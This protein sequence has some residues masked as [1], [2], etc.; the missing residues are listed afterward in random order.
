MNEEYEI[1]KIHMGGPL[2]ILR[3]KRMA[4]PQPIFKIRLK[5]PR[6]EK[7]GEMEEIIQEVSRPSEEMEEG[8]EIIQKPRAEIIFKDKRRDVNVNRELILARLHKHVQV[9]VME[10]TKKNIGKEDDLSS[11]NI[12]LV[13][14]PRDF[15]DE[16]AAEKESEVDGEQELTRE[17]P[18]MIEIHSEEIIFKP[19]KGKKK[20]VIIEPTKKG[21]EENEEQI[22]EKGEKGEKEKQ[23]KTYKK[24]YEEFKFGDQ[25]TIGKDIKINKKAVIVRL[26]KREKFTV[27]TS[28]YYMNNRKIYVQKIAELFRPYRKEILEGAN[29]ASCDT[30]MNVDFKILTHQKI[31]RDYLNVYTPYRGLLLYHGLGSGKTCSSIAIAEGMKTQR[32]IVLMTPASL[33]MNFFSELKKCGDIMYKKTQYWEFIPT[34]GNPDYVPTLSKI[35]QIPQEVIQRKKGAWLVD[36][37]K[38]ESNFAELTTEQQHDLDEQLNL[39]IRAK[40]LDINYN[41]LNMKKLQ[42]LTENFTKNIFDNTT[43]L[44]DEA[45]NFVSRIVNKIKK[46]GTIS[47]IL[48]DY[49]MKATNVKI[50]LLSGTPIINYPHELGILFNILRGYIKTWT[51]QLVIKNTAPAGF[52]VNREQIM[53]MFDRENFRMY[54][55]VEYSGNNLTITR[56]PYGFVNVDH[57]KER[58]EIKRGGNS[59]VDKLFHFFGGKTKKA[60]V[61]KHPRST[62]KVHPSAGK[63]IIDEDVLKINPHYKDNVEDDDDATEEARHN[64]NIMIQDIQKGGDP[65]EY[66][67]VV[68]DEHGNITDED[69]INEV[70]RILKKNHLEINKTGSKYEELK[71]L[72]DDQESFFSMFVDEDSTQIKNPNVFKK[73]ILGLTS[74]FRSAE[75]SL[76]PQFVKTEEGSNYHIV[77][78]E[79]SEF[80]FS[81]YEKIRK[82]EADQDKRN[83]QKKRNLAKKGNADELFQ[84]ASSYRIFSRAACNFAFPNPPGRPMPDK[85]ESAVEEDMDEED[86]TETDIDALSP[87]ELPEIDEFAS[88]EDV[89]KKMKT[90]KEPVDYKNRIQAALKMIQ[91]DPEKPADQQ[92][93]TKDSLSMYSP[94]FIKLLENLQDPENKGLHLLYSQFRTI[95]G[96]GIIKLVLE[97]NGFAEFKI[98]KMESSDTW[99]I[100]ENEEDA[101]KPRFVLYT[102][103]ETP[104]EKEMIRNIY[105]SNWEVVPSSLAEK[106]RENSANNFYGEIIKIM[107]ITA[108]G[109]EGINLRNTRFVHIV[110]PYWHVVR[111]EQV[112]GRARRICSH[113]DLPEELRTVKVFLYLSVFSEEQKTNKKNIEM[114]NRDTSRIDGRPITTDESLL[115]S[116]YLK[117]N[118]NTQ[119]LNAVKET[120]IDCSLY[121]PLNKD[122][123]LVCYGFGKVDSTAFASYPTL[124][125]DLSERQEINVK[126]RKLVLKASKPIDGVIYAI[127]PKT[128][129]AYDMNSYQQAL[130][131]A[132]ELILV[133]KIVKIGKGFRID[134]IE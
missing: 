108:S 40:Y 87:T 60:K 21:M 51:F 81:N 114:M 78:S 129:D 90:Y 14:P 120:A 75:E 69:F 27:R 26:P 131:G 7:K 41:G 46:P 94:K 47:Y 133:G 67:G 124:E 103:T 25:E 31:V 48:Y 96:V 9:R 37:T 45:H 121:N 64:T 13:Q 102:G 68:L 119:I 23:K 104:E 76:L 30:N 66:D 112:I 18:P 128:L 55:Y 125:Q 106:M 70:T 77:S 32:P 54:D 58:K 115:D 62:K 113:Q 111:I 16:G 44:I 52:K 95:E 122:E 50:V 43:V 127:D 82:D 15:I 49:L 5:K 34:T 118:I 80:Q 117:N 8:E 2:E 84:V 33:K 24:R 89:E 3:Q 38:K 57:K 126:K 56:N 71:A 1:D 4:K 17:K 59:G 19:K 39:M 93:L 130:I 10:K 110:E 65:D 79:M 134:K 53:K 86:I 99:E 109:A 88:E 72:P 101:G 123:N 12:P 100:I 85:K 20:M 63:Y 97:A 98:K 107:M 35:L 6:E 36:M 28:Q 91:Y 29:T 83:K 61:S 22:E 105:N 92:F 11:F 73:R 42:E 132:G 116:A 74:Y